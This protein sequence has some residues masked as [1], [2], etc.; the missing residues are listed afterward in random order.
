[1]RRIRA[2]QDLTFVSGEERVPTRVKRVTEYS[3]FTEM[4]DHEDP[5]S[6]GGELGESREE[7]LSVIRRIYPPEKEQLGVLAIE[8]ERA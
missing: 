6:I 1:M 4:L 5:I 8:I 2:G 7:L 3:S